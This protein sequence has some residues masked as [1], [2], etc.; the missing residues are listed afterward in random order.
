MDEKAMAVLDRISAHI[1]EHHL[2]I[3]EIIGTG[4]VAAVV[5]EP[6]PETVATLQKAYGWNGEPFF[7]LPNPKE[8]AHGLEYTFGDKAAAQ[9]LAAEDRNGRILL[10]IQSS[11]LCVNVTSNGYEIEP[12]TL[13]NERIEKMH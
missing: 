6:N 3:A 8:L 1:K 2:E 13:D 10:F 11:T 7:R 12:G 4:Q 5:V 9:W